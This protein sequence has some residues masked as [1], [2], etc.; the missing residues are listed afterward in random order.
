M[1]SLAAL[2]VAAALS[3]GLTA[4]APAQ[5][6][7]PLGLSI[8]AG[9]FFPTDSDA[10]DESDV[11]FALGLEYK[12]ANLTLQQQQSTTTHLSLSADWFESGDFR[13]FPLLLNLV[14]TQE[15]TYFSVGVGLT[16]AEYGRWVSGDDEPQ[17]GP[18]G[19]SDNDE[20]RTD[21]DT[22]FAYSIGIGYR[23][24]Q[25]STPVF[26][27]ARYFGCEKSVLNGFAV[28]VGVKL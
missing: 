5:E 28:Y 26:L 12:L 20:W 23:F 10:K 27:E 13:Q 17:E 11:W 4:V 19:L 24:Q 15:Q 25:G 16:F 21:E 8:R 7:K 2:A 3:A 22:L 6:A 9:G 1:K 14:A 18:A